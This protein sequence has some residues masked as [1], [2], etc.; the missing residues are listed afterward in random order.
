MGKDRHSNDLTIEVV[1]DTNTVTVDE[2]LAVVGDAVVSGN[3]T[4][5]GT[6]GVTGT[7]TGAAISATSLSSSGTLSVTGA[8]SL[9]GTTVT[10]TLA[11]NTASTIHASF[12]AGAFNFIGDWSSY[13]TLFTWSVS[14]G[15]VVIL[16]G[17]GT[18]RSFQ[19][20]V[21]DIP[22]GATI[23]SIQLYFKPVDASGFDA[24]LLLARMNLLSGVITTIATAN[25]TSGSAGAFQLVQD[26][27]LTEV[28]DLSAYA[29]SLIMKGTPG[30]GDLSLY[31]AR[32][33]GTVLNYS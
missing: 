16:P 33:T 15:G 26:T 5:S 23:T 32:I 13:A 31:A 24:T 17:G 20:S 14:S 22:D 28:V 3:A 19:H 4:V 9:H 2:N 27:G 10:G 29:Y 1:G 11:R 21:H 30:A 25:T 7:L 8:S 12:P 18:Q 6:L